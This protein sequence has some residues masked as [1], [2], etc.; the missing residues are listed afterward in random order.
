MNGVET[1][2]EF[3]CPICGQAL[4]L[5]TQYARSPVCCPNCNTTFA[6]PAEWA[7]WLSWFRALT[8]P[9]QF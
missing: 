9:M 5:S 7:E 1:S 2:L 8:E 6:L 4:M 3:T